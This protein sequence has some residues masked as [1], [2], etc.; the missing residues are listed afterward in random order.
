MQVIRKENETSVVFD[1]WS[2][3]IERLRSVA[4]GRPGRP[5]DANNWYGSDNLADAV[6]RMDSP[7][8]D[9]RDIVESVLGSLETRLQAL[10]RELV[11]T[12]YHDVAGAYPDI[13]R[14]LQGEPECMVQF[15]LRQDTTA[16][17]VCRVLIDGGANAG[18]TSDW[19]VR[20]AACLAAFVQVLTM[21]GRSVE[22][23]LAS[24]VTHTRNGSQVHDTLI[25]LQ[26]G[27]TPMSVDDIAFGLG[28]PA[29]LRRGVFEIRGNGETGWA[30]GNVGRT[31][32][33]HLESTVEYLRPEVVIERAENDRNIPDPDRDPIGYVRTLLVRA[34]LLAG[35]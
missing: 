20:R 32:G 15:D 28:H 22:I 29:T 5:N 10:A 21:L 6:S 9:G 24:P 26:S 11:A 7:W 34:G 27:G 8:A 16:G 31:Y 4:D 1:S 12:T 35:E 3:F 13:E 14:Y 23:W 17:Q 18:Y 19:M 25:C 33:K 30:D 2:A